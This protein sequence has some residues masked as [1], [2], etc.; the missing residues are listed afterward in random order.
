MANTWFATGTPI[1]LMQLLRL[2]GHN[3]NNIVYVPVASGSVK[4]IDYMSQNPL[5]VIYQSG[6]LTVTPPEHI[7]IIETKLDS[8]AESALEQIRQ[9]GHADKHRA[10]GKQIHLI[11]ANFSGQQRTLQEYKIQAL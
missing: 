2:T 10:S 5:P 4:C 7:Y 6:H 8:P 11:G 3:P 1:F 9:R